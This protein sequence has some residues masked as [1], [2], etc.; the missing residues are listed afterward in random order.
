MMHCDS[1]LCDACEEIERA[2]DEDADRYN[3]YL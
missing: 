3:D 2:L 1:E